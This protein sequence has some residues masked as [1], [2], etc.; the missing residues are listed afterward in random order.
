MAYRLISHDYGYRTP[1]ATTQIRRWENNVD[2]TIS[3]DPPESSISSTTALATKHKD[4]ISYI[5]RLNSEHPW[6]VRSLSRYTQRIMGALAT[7]HEL[8]ISMSEKSSTK[9]DKPNIT[10][11]RLQLNA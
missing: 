5:D 4:T 8:A 6:Y 10:I 3:H 2:D 1:F 11:S 9:K 7:Y